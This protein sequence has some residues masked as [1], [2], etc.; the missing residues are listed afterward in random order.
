MELGHWFA[1]GA[2]AWFWQPLIPAF[3]ADVLR[4]VALN[5]VRRDPIGAIW[6]AATAL[7]IDA[8]TWL[9]V[10][11]R[12]ADASYSPV[13]S[14]ALV[15]LL[16]VEGAPLLALFCLLAPTGQKKMGETDAQFNRG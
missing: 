10:G 15:T 7:A 13:E 8:A 9:F 6:I 14:A 4:L 3:G 5:T 16:K 12:L 2:S 11:M 1:L